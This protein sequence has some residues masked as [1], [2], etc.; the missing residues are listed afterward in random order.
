MFLLRDTCYFIINVF[1]IQSMMESAQDASLELK[2]D[3][4]EKSIQ[5]W[6]EN[7]VCVKCGINMIDA[8]ERCD[9]AVVEGSVW[10][11]GSNGD[12]SIICGRCR[13]ILK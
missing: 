2:E 13:G 9:K 1:C 12:S 7:S 8:V 3:E 11:S 6:R 5:D 10:S 4:I